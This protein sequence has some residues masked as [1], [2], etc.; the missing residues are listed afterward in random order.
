MMGLF[1]THP[2][3]LFYKKGMKT[4]EI[5]SY[6]TEYRG[7]LL[8]IESKTN[9]V[10]S[11]VELIDCVPLS[12][13]LWEMNFEKHRVSCPF[14]VLPYRKT[15]GDAFAWVIKNNAVFDE[16][17]KITRSDNRPYITLEEQF[18]NGK[19]FHPIDVKSERLACKFL[20][21]TMLM[22]WL[23]KNYFA[24]IAV[25]DIPTG[26][27]KIITDEIKDTEVDYVIEQINAK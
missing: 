14:D 20:G 11:L 10:I 24:L 4:W 7:K 9:T 18:L 2:W 22:Y 26:T 25:V 23:R 19:K 13:E 12:K 17:Y 1:V 27:T 21:D 6:P 3:P 16:K 5:R 8:I 15:N